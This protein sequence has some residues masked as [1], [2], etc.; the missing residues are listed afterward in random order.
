MSTKPPRTPEDLELDA[1]ADDPALDLDPAAVERQTLRH[2]AN[3]ATAETEAVT[4]DIK[5][6]D[7][8]G[9]PS[10]LKLTALELWHGGGK[11][12]VTFGALAMVA[13]GVFKGLE[14]FV[15]HSNEEVSRTADGLGKKLTSPQDMLM[16]VASELEL[17]TRD[18]SGQLNSANKLETALIAYHAKEFGSAIRGFDDLIENHP[19]RPEAASAR[20]LKGK[21]LVAMELPDQAVVAFTEFLSHHP[22]SADA[23]EALLLR[24]EAY[25]ALGMPAE[26]TA[27]FISVV[28]KSVAGS[29]HQLRAKAGLAKMEA[30]SARKPR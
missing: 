24:G 21:A 17:K 30:A 6:Y 3:Q 15:T 2:K 10:A 16:D 7:G 4:S 20:L 25:K 22:E 11:R 5:F 27:D 8:D 26:A 14:G 9:P 12:L 19:A 23:T 18:L 13:L 28:A 1:G 29:S